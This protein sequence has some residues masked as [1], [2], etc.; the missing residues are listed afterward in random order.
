MK[1][2]EYNTTCGKYKYNY[3]L[4]RSVTENNYVL[5]I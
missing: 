4:N 1:K 5:M 3:F 2:V